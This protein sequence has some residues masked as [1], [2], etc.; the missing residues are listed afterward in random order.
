MAN[1]KKCYAQ[2]IV[3]HY[4]DFGVFDTDE[5]WVALNDCLIGIDAGD[6]IEEF[7]SLDKDVCLYKFD[8]GSRL[9]FVFKF[10][11]IKV[12]PWIKESQ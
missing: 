8:D 11:E 10:L 9:L 1:K 4:S 3:D 6:T 7:I 12:L 2:K 5:M